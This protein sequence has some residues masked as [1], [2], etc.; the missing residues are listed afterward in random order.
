MP[1]VYASPLRFAFAVKRR[2]RARHAPR[3]V[4]RDPIEDNLHETPENSAPCRL[5]VAYY[6]QR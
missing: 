2:T 3:R 4:P 6:A 5:T 1:T